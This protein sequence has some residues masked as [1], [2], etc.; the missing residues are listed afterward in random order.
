PLVYD[1]AGGELPQPLRGGYPLGLFEAAAFEVQ[2]TIVPRGGTLVLYT[3]GV[4]EAMNEQREFFGRKRLRMALQSAPHG[5]A[6]ALCDDL[7]DEVIAYQGAA[8]LSDDITV[9]A[10][11]A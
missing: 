11:R 6:Q 7:V 9:L 1:G 5:S 3:D 10:V 4:T 8:G 2:R